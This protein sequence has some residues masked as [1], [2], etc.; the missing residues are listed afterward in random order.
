VTC[1]TKALVVIAAGFFVLHAIATCALLRAAH[2]MERTH[3]LLERDWSTPVAV[4]RGRGT[5]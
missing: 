2:A 3:E 5:E 4:T 1:E